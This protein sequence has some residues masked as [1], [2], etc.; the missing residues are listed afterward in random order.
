MRTWLDQRSAPS[1]ADG[2]EKARGGQTNYSFRMLSSSA[3]SGHREILPPTWV[4]LPCVFIKTHLRQ[5]GRAAEASEKKRFF[6]PEGRESCSVDSH[7]LKG[8]FERKLRLCA[9]CF[10]CYS[11]RPLQSLYCCKSRH[12]NVSEQ[13][14]V[15]LNFSFRNLG[16]FSSQARDSASVDGKLNFE[17]PVFS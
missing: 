14:L 15:S 9:F 4:L 11:P 7:I 17:I 3:G 1:V 8:M 5:K 10:T 2:N 13:V 12:A 16:C 6:F